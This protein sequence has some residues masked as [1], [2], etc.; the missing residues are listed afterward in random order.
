MDPAIKGT[1]NVLTASKEAGVQRVVITSSISAIIPNPKWPAN[2]ELN[3]EC[4]TDID[5]CKRNGVS[6]SFPL[7]I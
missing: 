4:W 1:I 3:E 2:V 5:Y 7:N 6:A